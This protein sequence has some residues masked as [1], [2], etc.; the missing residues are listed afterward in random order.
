MRVKKRESLKRRFL[1]FMAANLAEVVE[2]V[3]DVFFNPYDFYG[4][5]KYERHRT[6]NIAHQLK[7][8]GDI[9][10]IIGEDG[11]IYFRFTY[12][13]GARLIKEIPLLRFRKRRWDGK[14]RQ[15]V[16]D[17]PEEIKAKREILRRKLNSLGFGMLQRSVYITPF[18]IGEELTEFLEENGLEEYAIVFEMERLSGESERELAN[19]VWK[20]DKLFRRYLDFTNKWQGFLEKP[21]SELLKK[22]DE[23]REEYFSILLDDPGLPPELLPD[24]WPFYQANKIFKTLVSCASQLNKVKRRKLRR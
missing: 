22:F 11:N 5:S 12:K 17:I 6:A 14:W 1:Y 9:E 19:V 24:D 18:N 21:N 23:C 2:D 8:T 3:Y 20:L 15:I 13:G 4:F 7:K 16:F 10:K